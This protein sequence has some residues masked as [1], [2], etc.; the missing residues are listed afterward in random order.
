MYV[1]RIFR[2]EGTEHTIYDIFHSLNVINKGSCILSP[3]QIGLF[4]SN[5]FQLLIVALASIFIQ[6]KT[7]I[8]KFA[9]LQNFAKIQNF[10][11]QLGLAV[12]TFIGYIRTDRQRNCNDDK[13]HD[14]DDNDNDDN[15]ELYIR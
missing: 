12:F 11:T 7:I 5:I 6:Y 1:Y 8:K 13:K 15:D 3:I 10:C 14:T 2:I 4:L 9:D